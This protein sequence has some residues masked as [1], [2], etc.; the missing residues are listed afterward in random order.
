MASEDVA[1]MAGASCW[2]K[3]CWV[4]FPPLAT[5]AQVGT[6]REGGARGGGESS[7]CVPARRL[8]RPA[9]REGEAGVRGWGGVTLPTPAL[10]DPSTPRWGEGW[11]WA[12][13]SLSIKPW[14]HR[15][16]LGRGEG[17][18]QDASAHHEC[19]LGTERMLAGDW[20]ECWL[21]TISIMIPD[22]MLN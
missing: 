4:R 21:G 6:V 12:G 7:W 13:R 16:G 20:H 2:V 1:A 11:C 18:V 8:D 17:G 22:K 14:P 5:L 19:W 9:T 10:L 3:S 15:G